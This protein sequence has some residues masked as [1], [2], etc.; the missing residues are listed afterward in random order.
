ME[1]I[2]FSA[3]AAMCS[4]D[5]VM[6]L[7]NQRRSKRDASEGDKRIIVQIDF[8]IQG[9]MSRAFLH[10]REAHLNRK[11]L[12]LCPQLLYLLIRDVRQVF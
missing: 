7:S 3:S 5:S 11:E 2:I 12:I 10:A 8:D 4:G 1:A 6:P 9:G